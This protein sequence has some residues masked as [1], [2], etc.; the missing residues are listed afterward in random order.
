MLPMDIL[1][2]AVGVLAGVLI[3]L[4]WRTRKVGV[5]LDKIKHQLQDKFLDSK[6]PEGKM[7]QFFEP[8]SDKEKFEK[9]ETIDELLK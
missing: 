1:F 3:T 2:F 7:A 6:V 8:I 5:E 9:A 4:D